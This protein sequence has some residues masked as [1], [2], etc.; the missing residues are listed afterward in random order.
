MIVHVGVT[1]YLLGKDHL[2]L[3]L[4]SWE[5]SLHNTVHV[6]IV[7]KVLQVHCKTKVIITTMVAK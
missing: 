5:A 4:T 2:Q 1:D 7:S 3:T 6:A